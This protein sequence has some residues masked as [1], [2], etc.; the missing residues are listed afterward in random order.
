MITFDKDF[1][2][3]LCGGTHVDA[4]GKIGVFKITKEDSVAAGVRR[5][6]AVTADAAEAFLNK[7]L[8]E[9]N[10]IRG[11]FKNPTRTKQN[12]E[13]VLEENKNLKKE[14]EKLQ[15]AQAGSLKDDLKKNAELINGVNFIASKLPLNDGKAI[16]TLAMQLEQEIGNALIVF[17]AEVK[18]KPQIMVSVS[19]NI[20]EE[21]GLNAGKIVN[22][23]A[24]EIGGR[25]GG[26]PFFATAGGKDTAGLANAI[27]KAREM[28]N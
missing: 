10:A 22:E 14:I 26:Q 1:S 19:K 8:E 23:L 9:L 15:N 13:A 28:M 21:K 12:V 3:E 25:G 24:A 17:A 16:K 18:G 11:L 7:E 20:V 6:E 5:I 4:T 2:Q 27:A